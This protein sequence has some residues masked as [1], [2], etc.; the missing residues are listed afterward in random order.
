MR[1]PLHRMKK[2]GFVEEKTSNAGSAQTWGNRQAFKYL[3][4]NT[5]AQKKDQWQR[6]V[7]DSYTAIAMNLQLDR[8]KEFRVWFEDDDENDD[9][10]AR[11]VDDIRIVYDLASNFVMTVV[12][13]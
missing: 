6:V 2:N 9:D 10:E 4:T 3:L 7:R 11:V 13:I 8:H 5:L 1:T 12:Q